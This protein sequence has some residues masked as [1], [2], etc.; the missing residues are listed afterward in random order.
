MLYTLNLCVFIFTFY[1]NNMKEINTL[2]GIVINDNIDLF[3]VNLINMVALVLYLGIIH[4]SCG[5]CFPLVILA[6]PSHTIIKNK[7]ALLCLV[8][9]H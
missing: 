7:D 2:K 9:Y 3:K 4:S 5:T 6:M 8:D 1:E